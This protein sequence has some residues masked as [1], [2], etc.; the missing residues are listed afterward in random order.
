MQIYA[1]IN[2]M[3]DYVLLWTS[4][5]GAVFCVTS[6]LVLVCKFFMFMLQMWW[7]LYKVG[8]LSPAL[9]KQTKN[10]QKIY[11]DASMANEYKKA[12]EDIAGNTSFSMSNKSNQGL[13]YTVRLVSKIAN[14]A[15][16]GEDC[17]DK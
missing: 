5:I 13:N 9:R 7:S 11:D 15:L 10:L 3:V 4:I 2:W 17:L 8:K 1:I 14:N 12:L 16:Y 6:G